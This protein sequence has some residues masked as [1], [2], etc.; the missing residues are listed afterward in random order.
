MAMSLVV[1]KIQ[2]YNKNVPADM[3]RLKWAALTESPFRFYRGTCHLFAE[4]FE[5]LYGYKSKIKTWIC[6]D[7]H[8][9]NF[10]SYKG[11]N[12]LV[13][14]D[15]NDFDEAILANPA[16][17]LARFI[18]S[19]IIVGR[20]MKTK[21]QIIEDVASKVLKSYINTLHVGKAL[22]MEQEVAHSVLKQYFKQL[23]QRNREQFIL[24]HT[25]T[26]K[27][28]LQ[29]K[30]DSEKFL[31]LNEKIGKTVYEALKSL[32]RKNK[33]FSELEF[34]D[35]AIRIAGTGSLGLSRYCVLCYHKAKNKHYLIDIKE[36]RTSCH[37]RYV[38][39]RQPEFDDEAER[40]IY[41]E[42]VMQFCPPA[43]L[44]T[45]RIGEKYFIVKELQPMID[46]LSVQQ[47]KSDFSLFS[48][49][50]HQMAPLIA[51]AQLRSSGYKGSSTADELIQFA[52]KKRLSEK[53]LPVCIQLADNNDQYYKEFISNLVASK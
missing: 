28:K 43:F 17:E 52:D 24:Q 15:I 44:S 46:K 14:F 35:V 37:K 32:L 12:R 42:W 2:R 41:A 3:L 26:K 50:A 45:M 8:F 31:P 38:S 25:E 11:E 4:D 53:L 10:G 49:A 27:G 20:Q 51:Y 36:A 23:Q 16:P 1:D 6:G 19:I 39:A 29:L 30:Y 7:L 13:Y 9:E 47:F 33:H 21:P 22:V 48:A 5:A 40:I 18:T 34:N